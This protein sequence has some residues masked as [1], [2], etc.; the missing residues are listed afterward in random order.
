MHF[1]YLFIF[2]T[3][4]VFWIVATSA[5]LYPARLAAK[6]NPKEAVRVE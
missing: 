5:G 4:S 6:L 1:P 2:L 3:T